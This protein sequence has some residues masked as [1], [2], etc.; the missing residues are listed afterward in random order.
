MGTKDIICAKIRPMD[1]G[2]S[3][4]RPV[5]LTLAVLFAAAVI[6]YS[7]IWMYAVRWESEARLGISS[8]H[9][10]TARSSRITNVV[11][12][13]AAEQAGLLV[14][15]QIVAVNG[16]SL[17]TP[18]PL[19]EALRRGHPGDII[20]LTVE[21][22]GEPA[23]LTLDATL[24]PTPPREELPLALNQVRF[25]VNKGEKPVVQVVRQESRTPTERLFR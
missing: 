2:T 23:P 21:R 12:G 1:R 4:P 18:N 22:P 6:L 3:L 24:D 15:D 11:E 8:E 10:P 14:N 7:A 5:L 17:E 25:Y 9:S 19:L 20:R 13:S 16:R